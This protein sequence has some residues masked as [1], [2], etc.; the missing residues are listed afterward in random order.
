MVLSTGFVTAGTTVIVVVGGIDIG[1]VA[2]IICC[3]VGVLGGSSG[4]WGLVFLTL[5][6]IAFVSIGIT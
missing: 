4:I 6:L 1:I 3:A 2:G 5:I